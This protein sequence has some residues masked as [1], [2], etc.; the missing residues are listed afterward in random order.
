MR[1]IVFFLAA[2]WGCAGDTAAGRA[3][4]DEAPTCGTWE[5][6]GHP[7][8]LEWCTSCHSSRLDGDGRYG[9]PDGVDL[10]T[11]AGVR[12]WSERVS[13]RALAEGADMPPATQAP[14]EARAAVAAW[15]ACG[16][17]GSEA[18]L[19]GGENNPDLLDGVVLTG[20]VTLEADT[21]LLTQAFEGDDWLVQA[22]SEGPPAA[23]AEASAWVDGV[24]ERWSFAPPLPVWDEEAEASRW[25]GLVDR[26][27][28][29]GSATAA[30]S[31]TVRRETVTD[32]DPRF[33]DPA[34]T[35]VTAERDGEPVLVWWFSGTRM[36]VAQA[37]WMDDGT[38]RTVLNTA[39][40]AQRVDG[41]GF[42][43]EPGGSWA[44]RGTLSAAAP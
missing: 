31:W 40:I 1:A 8:V 29:S 24:E 37:A 5:T 21:I 26:V 39:P 20:G 13:A 34:P 41:P 22:F 4:P 36:L 7:F 42:P 35:R 16:A 15:L 14:P 32:P 2:G 23:L 3:L 30:E 25:E 18:T 43:L 12:R 17:P 28:P 6:V 19:P 44:A 9:A 38:W 11:L 33:M 27:D 10:D